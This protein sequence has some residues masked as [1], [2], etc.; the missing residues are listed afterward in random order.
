[1][2]ENMKKPKIPKNWEAWCKRGSHKGTRKKNAVLRSLK[3]GLVRG[4]FSDL[5][6]DP[7]LEPSNSMYPSVEHLVDRE[8]HNETV[9]ETRIV[10]DMKSHLSEDEFWRIIEH[11]FNVGMK[12]GKIKPPFGK[13]LPRKW[14]P[15]RHY[16]RRNANN[17]MHRIG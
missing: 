14:S 1:M 2:K 8:N 15:D 4:Y 11:L 12:K 5:V 3:S 6:L 16:T 13:R 17:E 9:V 7:D 10:N